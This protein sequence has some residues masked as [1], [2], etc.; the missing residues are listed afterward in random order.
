MA[1]RLKVL[2]TYIDSLT[3]S[4]LLSAIYHVFESSQK[5]FVVTMNAEGLMI[6]QQD[7][8]F[9]IASESANFITPDGIGPIWAGSFLRKYTPKWFIRFLWIPVHAIFSL[10]WLPVKQLAGS[11]TI[12]PERISGSDLFWDI[13]NIAEE[14]GKSVYLL[15]ADKGVAEEVSRILKNKYPQIKIADF[16]HGDPYEE[17]LVD[18]INMSGASI[19]FVAWNQPKQEKWIAD[20]LSKLNINLAIGVGGTF[21][22]ASGKKKRAPKFFQFLGFEWLWRLMVEPRRIGRIFAAVPKFVYATIKYKIT[23]SKEKY[24][25]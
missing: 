24:D 6:A 18:K 21:N 1:K 7:E 10:L 16:Y 25:D 19:L 13:N 12:F 3:K 5:I 17:G 23:N 14:T 4:E 8:S 22:F 20:N 9:K 11:K 15:G 2:N